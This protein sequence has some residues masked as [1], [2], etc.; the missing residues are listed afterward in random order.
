[1]NVN[2]AEE[3]L[4]DYLYN[5][6]VS[7]IFWAEEAYA[8]AQEIGKHSDQIN[9]ANRE[10][11]NKVIAHN[12]AVDPAKRQRPTWGGTVSLVN[13]AKNLVSVIG[14]GFLSIY[15]EING[16]FIL[17]EDARRNARALKRLFHAANLVDG[18]E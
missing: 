1:L 4:R 15:F 9:N 12:E 13:Y 7:E 3:R 11:R 5:G 17:T 18:S 14:C 6:L 10:S 2:E 16:Q 8:L